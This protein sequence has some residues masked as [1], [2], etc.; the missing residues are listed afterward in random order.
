MDQKLER[1]CYTFAWAQLFTN[2]GRL[3]AFKHRVNR[4][5]NRAPRIVLKPQLRF[6]TN[7]YNIRFQ[8]ATPLPLK[9]TLDRGK[10]YADNDCCSSSPQTTRFAQSPSP[11]KTPN[12]GQLAAVCSITSWKKNNSPLWWSSEVANPPIIFVVTPTVN[13]K[14]WKSYRFSGKQS[15]SPPSLLLLLPLSVGLVCFFVRC[16]VRL[17]S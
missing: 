15:T 5:R 14:Y 10:K 16:W 4:L 7:S 13:T 2:L 11:N 3:S 9:V 1:L 6:S 8:S 12:L 17:L